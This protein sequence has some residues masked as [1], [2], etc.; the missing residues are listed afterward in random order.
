MATLYE[1]VGGIKT[2]Q[3][4]HKI[5]YDKVYAHAWLGQFF[6]GH[7]QE[8]IENRQTSFM[9]EKMGSKEPYLGKPIVQVHEN[10]YI[11]PKLVEVRHKLLSESLREAGVDEALATRWLRIDQAFMRQVTKPSV[12]VFYRDYH[13]PYKRRLIFPE[14]KCSD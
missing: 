14:P 3:V 13:F 4:V 6:A 7:S 12:Y 1:Q 9:A 11:T 10:M 5:F 2:L 8:A